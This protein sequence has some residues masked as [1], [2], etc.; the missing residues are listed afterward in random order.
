MF[1]L[2]LPGHG[3]M[4]SGLTRAGVDEWRQAA[5]L[6][7]AAVAE[8]AGGRPWTIVG[9]SNGAALALDHVLAALEGRGDPPP[10]RP[11]NSDLERAM[12]GYTD[13]VDSGRREVLRVE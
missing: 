9:N 7:A 13:C 10:P 11:D 4:P 5:R 6:A 3:T 12:A 1:A 2:R 8:R